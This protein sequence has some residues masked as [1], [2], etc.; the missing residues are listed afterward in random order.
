[1][2]TQLQ[3]IRKDRGFKSAKAFADSIGMSARTYTNYEQGV[4]SLTLEKAW[5]FADALE[6]TL[7]ELAGREWPRPAF[8]DPGQEALNAYFESMNSAGRGALVE[9]ARLMSG[10]PDTRIEKDRPASAGVQAEERSA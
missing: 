6:C 10:S 3:R 8:A 1:M 9:S 7:D 5:E 4:T 2:K